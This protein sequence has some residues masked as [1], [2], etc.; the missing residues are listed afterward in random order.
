MKEGAGKLDI[1]GTEAD[2]STFSDPRLAAK[3]RAIRRTAMTTSLFNEE[4]S[5]I[6]ISAAEIKYEVC[7]S[8]LSVFLC[9]WDH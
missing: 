4:S 5:T 7:F 2:T 9:L 3:E 8:S 6:D 1:V